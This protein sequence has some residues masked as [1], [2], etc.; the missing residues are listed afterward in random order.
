MIKNYEIKQQAINLLGDFGR[1]LKPDDFKSRSTWNKLGFNLKDG[2]KP[3][4][5]LDQLVPV[6]YIFDGKNLTAESVRNDED[7]EGFKTI[8]VELYHRSQVL[9]K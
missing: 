5:I 4:F 7:K 2:E 8:K 6:K 3:F 9:P 1:N